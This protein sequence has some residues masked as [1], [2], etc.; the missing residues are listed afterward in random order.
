MTLLAILQF[1]LYPY[2]VILFK[3]NLFS[4]IPNVLGVF[5]GKSLDRDQTMA[6]TVGSRDTGNAY[7][8]PH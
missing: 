4:T 1:G 3:G 2:G 6:R 8:D 5:R 7:S